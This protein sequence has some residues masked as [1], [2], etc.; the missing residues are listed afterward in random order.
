MDTY[1]ELF[2]RDDAE[3]KIAAFTAK[4]TITAET[5]NLTELD[6]EHCIATN[7][8]L[9]AIQVYENLK[10]QGTQPVS[11][12]A[13]QS[14][15]EL[16]CFHNST[17]GHSPEYLEELWF[18]RTRA[19]TSLKKQWQEL[20]FAEQLFADMDPKTPEA[21]CALICGNAKY[22]HANRAFKLYEQ[23]R[24]EGHAPNRDT[25]N[26]LIRCV[27]LERESGD[28]RWQLVTEL[29]TEM[30]ALDIC[31]D[32]AT[33][34]EVLYVL[35]R[36]KGWSRA[37]GNVLKVLRE[38]H[39]LDVTLSPAAYHFV[40]AA[41]YDERRTNSTILRQLVHHE[42]AGREFVMQHPQDGQ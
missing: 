36:C 39:K 38:A 30:S 33:F 19:E 18:S 25:Y 23:M 22:N 21:F 17:D 3:P 11:P 42:L 1:P 41:F 31:P 29:L 37:D 5:P 20:G 2:Y 28:A 10:K 15:L 24:S 4:D 40:A 16:V 34:V 14:L 12:K 6:L 9:N 8:V 26:A 27:V 13:T 32:N 35:S 7:Q